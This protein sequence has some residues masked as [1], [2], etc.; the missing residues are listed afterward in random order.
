VRSIAST[1]RI[2]GAL[3]LVQLV[4]LILPFVLLHPLTGSA[5]AYLAEAAGATTQIRVAVLLLFLNGALTVGISIAVFGAVRE[6][7]E[8]TALALVAAGVVM[9]LLQAVDNAHILT[10]L[11]LSQQFAGASGRPEP[12]GTIAAVALTTRRWVHYTELLAIDCW[13]LLLYVT[14]QRLALV[15]AVLTLFGVLTVMLHLVGIPLRRFAG[16]DP[17]TWMGVPMAVSHVAL[18]VWLMAKGF[19]EPQRPRRSEGT[20]A[21]IRPA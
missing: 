6:H 15:P 20:Q 16:A 12:F 21:Q 4:G 2:V 10:L 11:S 17:I 7:S 8:P 19:A 18:G 5:Q 14:L 3:L 1:G 13:I 9:L